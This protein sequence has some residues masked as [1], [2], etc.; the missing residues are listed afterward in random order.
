MNSVYEELKT[1][2][3]RWQVWYMLGNQDIKLKYR[4]SSLGPLWITLSMAV[5]IY[6]M[7]FLYG[8]LFRANALHYYPYLAASMLGWAYISRI[9]DESSYAFISAETYIK[10]QASAM[11]PFIM[12]IVLRNTLVFAHN[13]VVFIPI[14]LIFHLSVSWKLLLILPGFIL[15]GI[16]GIF[17]GSLL[18]IVGTRYRDFQQIVTSL[19]QVIYFL[20]PIMWLP[21]LLPA[22]YRWV[23][24]YNPFNGFLNLLRAPLLN[25]VLTMQNLLVIGLTTIVGFMLYCLFMKKFKHRIVFWL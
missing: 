6:S 21:S 10:N 14:I 8:H 3:T 12:R 25:K 13:I 4:R 5:T 15:I 9:L 1:L 2:V 17:W 23:A 20:T 7:G 24:S 19:M 18:A 16:N 11:T 22:K